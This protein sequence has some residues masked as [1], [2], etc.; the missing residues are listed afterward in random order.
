MVNFK[1]KN[2]ILDLNSGPG[3]GTSSTGPEIQGSGI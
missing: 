1:I 3:S 2:E